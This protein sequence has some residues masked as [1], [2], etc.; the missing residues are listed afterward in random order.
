MIIVRIKR[1][2]LRDVNNSVSSKFSVIAL[3]LLSLIEVIFISIFTRFIDLLI[4]AAY[5][6]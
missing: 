6:F 5:D 3:L 1:G 4:K 2:N